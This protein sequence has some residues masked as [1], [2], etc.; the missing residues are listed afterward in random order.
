MILNMKNLKFLIILMIFPLEGVY[1]SA[2]NPKCYKID[3]LEM[4]GAYSLSDLKI[5]KLKKNMKTSV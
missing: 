2:R 1:A 4:Q 5:I 3:Y